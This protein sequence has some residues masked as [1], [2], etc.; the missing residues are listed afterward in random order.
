MGKKA[1]AADGTLMEPIESR[2]KSSWGRAGRAVN[3]VLTRRETIDTDNGATK[4]SKERE[5]QYSR[6]GSQ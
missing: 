5:E 6:R 1:H 3:Q 2:N 4:G